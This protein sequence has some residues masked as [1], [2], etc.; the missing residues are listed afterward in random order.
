MKN[1]NIVKTFFSHGGPKV[2]LDTSETREAVFSSACSYW[3][4]EIYTKKSIHLGERILAI[5]TLFKMSA[6]VR[7]LVTS[8]LLSLCDS[9]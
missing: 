3:Y 8:S 7:I 9:L 5:G 4:H 1:H 6:I 2:G